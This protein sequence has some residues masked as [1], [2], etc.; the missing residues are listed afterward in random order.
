MLPP[1]RSDSDDC[2]YMYKA[3]RRDISIGQ[4]SS[5]KSFTTCHIFHRFTIRTP[6]HKYVRIHTH[7]H[8]F[9]VLLFRLQGACRAGRR[10]ASARHPRALLHSPGGR[11]V[12]RTHE[13]AARRGMCVCACSK[14]KTWISLYSVSPGAMCNQPEIVIMFSFTSNIR[15]PS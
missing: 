6:S 14:E 3:Y 8:S 10:A 1:T 15:S 4:M 5:I 2:T 13:C 11:S 12:A 9:S 7:T